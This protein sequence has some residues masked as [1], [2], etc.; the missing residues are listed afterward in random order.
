MRGV[1]HEDGLDAPVDLD[2]LDEVGVGS[3]W[4]SVGAGDGRMRFPWGADRAFA[5]ALDGGPARAAPSTVSMNERTRMRNGR[6]RTPSSL[7]ISGC[8]PDVPS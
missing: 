7:R 5:G 6:R 2:V 4:A 1:R 3:G 8:L